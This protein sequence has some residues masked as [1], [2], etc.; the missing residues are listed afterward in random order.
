MNS[1]GRSRVICAGAI[2]GTAFFLASCSSSAPPPPQPS[3]PP[4]EKIVEVIVPEPPPQPEPTFQ[5]EPPPPPPPCYDESYELSVFGSARD[6]ELSYYSERNVDLGK[7][8]IELFAQ[9]L[10]CQPDGAYAIHVHL[11]KARLHCDLG[12]TD[13]GIEQLEVLSRHPR[14]GGSDVEEAKYVHDFCLGLVDFN[15]HPLSSGLALA[16]VAPQTVSASV[17]SQSITAG[18]PVTYEALGIRLIATARLAATPMKSSMLGF[19]LSIDY[20]EPSSSVVEKWV[21]GAFIPNRAGTHKTFGPFLAK[22]VG[23][24]VVLRVEGDDLHPQLQ[25]ALASN[26]IR[27]DDR[28]T[29]K[30]GSPPFTLLYGERPIPGIAE[31]KELYQIFGYVELGYKI[32]KVVRGLMTPETLFVD[33]A[34]SFV[35]GQI[36]GLVPATY[37]GLIG[38]RCNYCG[39]EEALDDFTGCRRLQCPK[40]GKAIADIC[41]KSD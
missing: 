22:G 8:A 18:V 16:A 9:Y 1:F 12:E 29:K 3:P 25:F 28:I 37:H 4:V 20:A 19:D 2:A 38:Y 26:G 36:V 31:A 30:I 17:S 10:R 40:C 35:Q 6:Y 23:Y 24:L 33:V 41:L 7:K 27:H 5:P 34:I 11:R 21:G 39:H 15:G 14:A 32:S 13:K